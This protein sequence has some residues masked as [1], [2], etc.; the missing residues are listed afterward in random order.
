MT[1]MINWVK[2]NGT[3]IQTNT[4]PA[5]VDMAKSLG[6]KTPEQIQA[7]AKAAAEKAAQD[8]KDADAKAKAE[9]KAA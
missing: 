5:N 8:K 1:E 6:W 3:K 4:L 2:P 9:A 7:E